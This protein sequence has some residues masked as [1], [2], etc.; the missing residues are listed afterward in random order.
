MTDLPH[1]D[2]THGGFRLDAT[3][4]PIVCEQGSSTEIASSV[5][6]YLMCPQGMCVY[7]DQFGRPP[8]LFED[9]PLDLSPLVS[10][11]QTYEPRLSAGVSQNPAALVDAVAR[12]LAETGTTL[13]TITAQAT[14]DTTP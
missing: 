2:T 12:Q 7:D 9:Q 3:G 1:F 13:V 4:K 6:N 8:V 10:G 5:T 11:I 14:V